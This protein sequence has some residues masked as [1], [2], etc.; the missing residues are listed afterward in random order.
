MSA[1]LTGVFYTYQT[2]V[3]Y[4]GAVIPSL[5][6]KHHAGQVLWAPGGLVVEDEARSRR[7]VTTYMVG[8]NT[9]HG[10][11]AAVAA[12]MLW[13]DR[14][15]LDWDRALRS[16][17][18]EYNGLPVPIDVRL[19]ERLIDEE[20]RQV[21]E[22]LLDAVVPGGARDN[23]PRH[24]AVV[25]MCALLDA[26]ASE[27]DICITDLVQ[28]SGLSFRQLRHRFT[29]ELGIS[30]RGYLRWRRLRRAIGSIERG[31][32]L[33]DAAIDGGFADGAHFSRVFKAQFGLAPSRALSSIRF[34]GP[35]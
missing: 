13:V 35:L 31:A 7:E 30:P 22:A 14:D 16:W 4:V 25:R 3:L 27:R 17:R 18:R 26:T 15:D 12:A 28:Q 21:A 11:G 19:D 24:P 1:K 32:S 33:T 2:H 29:E 20:A 8:P 10:H 6:H 9:L 34:G 23:A 5:R